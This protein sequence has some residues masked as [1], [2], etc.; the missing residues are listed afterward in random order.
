MSP[1][2]IL[3]ISNSGPETVPGSMPGLHYVLFKYIIA[4]NHF[5]NEL[6]ILENLLEGESSAISAIQ[7]SYP[8]II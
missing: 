8:I 4:I 7:K 5:N 6:T 1:F 3:R 2:S